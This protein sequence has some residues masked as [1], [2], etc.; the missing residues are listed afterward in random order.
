[1]LVALALG[2]VSAAHAADPDKATLQ[3][4]IE[5]L[6]AM[7][8]NLEQRVSVLEGRAPATASASPAKPASPKASAS[9]AT[10]I[11]PEARVA[12]PP[13]APTAPHTMAAVPRAAP[14][15]EG[16]GYI[17]PEAALRATWSKVDAGM[18]QGEVT[19]LLGQPSKKLTLDGRTVW[20]YY[21]PATG[22]GSVF[23]TDAGRVS[24]R[25]SPFGLGW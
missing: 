17:S 25:Q 5:A 11:A 1:M 7:V 22:S 23:F 9:P 2:A 18:D 21:Y 6:K 20:Y 14:I 8:R 10:A 13:A 19:R 3:K 15:G 16:A 12:I 4:E 24:S